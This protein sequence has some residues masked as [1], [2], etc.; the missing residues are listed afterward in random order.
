MR[1]QVSTVKDLGEQGLLKLITPYCDRN[2]VGDDGAV[3]S[4]V[5]TS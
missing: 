1:E 4:V 3:T 2:L 5:T